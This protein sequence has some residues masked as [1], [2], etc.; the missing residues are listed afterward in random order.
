MKISLK[1]G[2]GENFLVIVAE[3]DENVAGFWGGFDG[4]DQFGP[5][6]EGLEGYGGGAGVGEVS[7][8]LCGNLGTE[9]AAPAFV[10]G[11]GG[12]TGK[13]EGSGCSGGRAGGSSS[14]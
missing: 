3:L 2:L 8:G 12:V 7:A 11:D 6:A 10:V 4:S 9:G 14:L 1:F 13:D 5:V